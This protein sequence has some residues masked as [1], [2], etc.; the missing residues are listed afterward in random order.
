MDVIEKSYLFRAQSALSALTETATP[1]ETKA[2]AFIE[3]AATL[4][5]HQQPQTALN[6]LQKHGNELV[7]KAAAHVIDINGIF[8][9]PQA[10][11]LAENYV[12]SI[13]Q[14][15]LLDQLLR[16]AKVIPP[17]MRK[18]LIGG[19]SVGNSVTEGAPKPTLSLSLNLSDVDPIKST[20]LIV[21]SNELARHTSEAGRRMFEAELE[22]AITRAVNS[23]VLAAFLDSGSTVVAAGA[24]PLASL[25]AGLQAAIPSSGYVC[26]VSTGAANYL[27]T[28]TE[29]WGMTP[30]GGQFAPGID[31]VAVDDMSGMRIFPAS[32]FALWDGGLQIKSSGEAAIDLRTSPTAP[33]EPTSLFQTD[34]TAILAER[35]WNIAGDTSGVVTVEGD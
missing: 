21:L 19:A 31:V 25:R 9:G 3:I 20:A 13:A 11:I 24:D 35:F 10:Q 15:S 8:A 28:C 17:N 6:V 2:Q 14:Y 7:A 4:A 32:N 29:N 1:T 23:A 33:Y 26:A 22:R 16:Y 12:A 5:R 27:A 30:R 34:C 18:V